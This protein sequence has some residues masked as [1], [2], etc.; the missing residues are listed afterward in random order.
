[1][2]NEETRLKSAVKMSRKKPQAK[3]YRDSIK[4]AIEKFDVFLQRKWRYL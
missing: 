4:D 2:P 3:V 1:M